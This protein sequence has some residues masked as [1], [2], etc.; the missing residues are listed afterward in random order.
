MGRSILGEGKWI[1]GEYE[2]QKV[3]SCAEVRFKLD[4]KSKIHLVVVTDC[5]SCQC[6][7]WFLGSARSDWYLHAW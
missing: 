7:Y 5:E 6:L 1:R 2:I 3:N 4:P